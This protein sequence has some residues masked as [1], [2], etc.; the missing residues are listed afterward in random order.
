MKDIILILSGLM[1]GYL[2]IKIRQKIINQTK[3]LVKEKW[4]ISKFLDGMTNLV[5]SKKWG[6]TISNIFNLR[7]WIIYG[8]IIGVIFG[9]GYFKGLR[10]RPVKIDLGYGKEA[11]IKLDSSF[12][13]IYKDGSVWVEDNKGNKV[14]QICVKDIPSLQKKLSPFGIQFRPFFLSGIAINKNKIKQDIGLGIS[15]IKYF[16]WSMSNWFSNNGVWIGINY[17]ITDNFHL[18][19]GVGKSYKGDNL[20]GLA[21]RFD[22]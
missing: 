10:H 19:G 15:W 13:H 22:F 17:K 14:K 9:Y 16:R 12:L 3:D 11:Q 2:F 1:G 21:G 7:M 8:I 6:Q 4:N 20:L 5:D 18:G